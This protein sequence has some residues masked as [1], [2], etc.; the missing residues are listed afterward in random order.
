[1]DR[2][3]ARD[4]RERLLTLYVACTVGMLRRV[5]ANNAMLLRRNVWSDSL[6]A[7]RVARYKAATG[8]RIREWDIGTI[9]HYAG[10][11]CSWCYS[12]EGV[13]FVVVEIPF[14]RFH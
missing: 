7:D 11:H 14:A 1:M 4:L 8:A 2:M 6:L 12:P 10:F 3:F 9:G 5:Y 13:R